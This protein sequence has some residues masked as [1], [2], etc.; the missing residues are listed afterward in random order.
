[1]KVETRNWELETGKILLTAVILCLAGSVFASQRLIVTKEGKSFWATGVR[2]EGDTVVYMSRTTGQEESIPV[3]E[4]HGVIPTV[5][6]GQQ[7][8][9]GEIQKYIDRIKKLQR[10][11]A[12][13][14]RQLNSI[15]QEW[16]LLQKP[17]P[18]L[19]NDIKR[20]ADAYQSSDKGMAVY[21]K[22]V[23]DLGMVRYK[24]MQGKYAGRLD[25]V[26]EEIR[27]DYVKV[28]RK[29]LEETAALPE[30]I[31]F[32]EFIH[33]ENLSRDV[34]KEADPADKKAVEAMLEST[35]A[36]V[37]DA[38][39]RAGYKAFAGSKTVDA[40]LE[41]AHILCGVREYVAATPEQKSG[42]EKR[43]AMLYGM[44][45][46][47]QPSYTISESGFPFDKAAAGLRSQLGMY[48]SMITFTDLELTEQ[49]FIVPGSKPPALKFGRPFS[50]P[51]HIVINR[52]QPADRE[53]A[54]RVLHLTPEGMIRHL[55][56]L[57]R[58]DFV[59]GRATVEYSESF[60]EAAA[61]GG[62]VPDELGNYRWYFYV[63]YKLKREKEDPEW[64]PLSK[65][66]GWPIAP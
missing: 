52:A 31:S 43:I 64:I 2:Q 56:H 48:C 65:S 9:P 21:R 16:E 20:L 19:E 8:T 7:Y 28:N 63:V 51:L 26:L 61:Y 53:F 39:C 24:D 62:L 66:C 34:A 11:H 13:L 44:I 47:A 57:G 40:Y 17:S 23:L 36:N 3:S 54:L 42:V 55:V 35:R 50:V 27:V 6:R 5:V 45:G 30:K 12:N 58:L 59:N 32:E 15:L 18:E 4:L 25:N 46:K 1:M 29:R 14:Y 33:F 22:T 37:F 60:A 38:Q 49:C 10:L 41:A